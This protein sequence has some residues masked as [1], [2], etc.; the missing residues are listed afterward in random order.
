VHVKRNIEDLV[1][2]YDNSQDLNASFQ[3]N[4]SKN[5]DDADILKNDQHNIEP[6]DVLSYDTVKAEIPEYLGLQIESVNDEL[7]DIE[8]K[9]IVGIEEPERKE[10]EEIL[11]EKENISIGNDIVD[12][13]QS[14]DN[15]IPENFKTSIEDVQN[16]DFTEISEFSEEENK[17]DI[18]T[19]L[20]HKMINGIESDD[21]KNV[22]NQ[23]EMEHNDGI[24]LNDECLDEI[25]KFNDYE[26]EDELANPE[27]VEINSIDDD[28]TLELLELDVNEFQQTEP[29]DKDASEGAVDYENTLELQNDF[30]TPNYECFNFM[31]EENNINTK[32]ICTEL[33]EYDKQYPEKQILKICDL[34]Y[35]EGFSVSQISEELN[36]PKQVVVEILY[37]IIDLVKD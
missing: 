24:E 32:A 30:S 5:P 2:P 11:A 17:E 4:I 34:K 25:D 16:E 8:E 22:Y 19:P 29:I 35:N 31:P 18:V 12:E 33:E 7:S 6:E 21:S 3:R 9:N 20:V 1:K 37:D 23:I 26:A 13:L 28:C 27:I 14:S 36:L 15:V 10:K